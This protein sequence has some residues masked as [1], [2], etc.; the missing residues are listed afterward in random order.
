MSREKKAA[1]VKAFREAL[2]ISQVEFGR[3][4]G[5]SH[6]SV[7]DYEGG[8]N[9]SD[10]A[11]YAILALAHE[12]G[13]ADLV[14]FPGELAVTRD[15]RPAP[16]PTNAIGIDLHALLDE[17]MQSGDSG[18]VLTVENLLLYL[19]QYTRKGRP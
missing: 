19:T 12:R 14:L 11:W 10:A 1:A 13:W 2:G 3:L 9:I 6:Q 18:V 17:L 4:I 5:R 8:K 7:Q 15:F 16:I